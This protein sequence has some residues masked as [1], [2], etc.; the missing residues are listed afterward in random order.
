MT[1]GGLKHG[2][3]WSLLGESPNLLSERRV[4]GHEPVRL[5]DLRLVDPTFRAKALGAPS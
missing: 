3:G 4:L 5:E 1:L 2:A